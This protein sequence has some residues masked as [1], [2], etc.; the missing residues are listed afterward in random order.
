MNEQLTLALLVAAGG[1]MGAL[2]RFGICV[3]FPSTG[4]IGWSTLL[5]NFI[6]CTLITLILFS[7]GSISPEMRA[8]LFIGVFGGF[9]TMSSVSLETVE[10]FVSGMAGMAF[11]NFALNMVACIGGGFIG[12]IFAAF[13]PI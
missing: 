3:A 12:R 7:M 4:G 13:L 11:L 8:F 2:M 1:A 10:L 9:T 5:A 6:G